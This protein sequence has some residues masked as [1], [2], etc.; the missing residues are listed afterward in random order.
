MEHGLAKVN[1]CGS[2]CRDC[3][4]FKMLEA[5]MF[6]FLV[7]CESGFGGGLCVVA[8]ACAL[9]KCVPDQVAKS[10]MRALQP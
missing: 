9:L 4:C 6:I 8:V 7:V 10:A 3:Y 1:L 2:V 5:V